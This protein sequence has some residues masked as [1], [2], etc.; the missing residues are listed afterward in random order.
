[1]LII[2]FNFFDKNFQPRA[3]RSNTQI[4]YL[5]GLSNFISQKS[6]FAQWH[7]AGEMLHF[8]PP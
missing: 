2:L 5:L 4:F 3:N 1:M 6:K 8:K 7:I